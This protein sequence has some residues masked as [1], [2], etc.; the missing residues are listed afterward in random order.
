MKV[1]SIKISHQWHGKTIGV[2][3]VGHLVLGF[4]HMDANEKR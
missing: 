4:W 3:G 1:Y 2:Q